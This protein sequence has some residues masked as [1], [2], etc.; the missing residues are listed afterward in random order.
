MAYLSRSEK[1][2]ALGKADQHVKSAEKLFLDLALDP[3]QYQEHIDQ[4]RTI[5]DLEI[6]KLRDE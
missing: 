3:R 5:C 2:L 6:V 1:A 4:L